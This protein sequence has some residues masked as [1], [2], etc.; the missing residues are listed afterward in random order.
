MKRNEANRGKEKL[1]KSLLGGSWQ[2]VGKA[3][4]GTPFWNLTYQGLREVGR[5]VHFARWIL[6]EQKK[7]LCMHNFAQ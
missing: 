1:C 4:F 3:F 5:V 6:V 7:S 2:K